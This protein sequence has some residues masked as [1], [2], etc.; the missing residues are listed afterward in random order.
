MNF[1]IIIPVYNVEQYLAKCL[2]SVLN[3]DISYTDYEVILVN[4]GSSDNSETIIQNYAIKHS[5]IRYIKQDNGGP[6]KARNMGL[7]HASGDYIWFVDA[8][9]SIKPNSLLGLLDYLKRHNVDFCEFPYYKIVGKQTYLINHNEKISNQRV[10]NVEYLSKYVLPSM[11]WDYVVKREVIETNN[12]RFTPNIWHEDTEFNLRLL[13]HCHNISF[14]PYP[15]YFYLEDRP[16]STMNNRASEHFIKRIDS[17]CYILNMLKNHYNDYETNGYSFQMN[18]RFNALLAYT[19]LELI[20]L[21]TINS[22]GKI[23]AQII[24]KNKY[25][26]NTKVEV[27]LNKIKYSTL[28]ICIRNYTLSKFINGLYSS[29]GD[30]LYLIIKLIRK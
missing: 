26:Y 14:Y 21:S 13:E 28:N 17:Y 10:S 23:Y 25:R 7:D 29:F 11:P 2:D 5:N 1:S 8:D 20:P 30:A 15:L 16:N 4:D 27:R 18:K 6:S 19:T 24:R 9:D 22:K 3:Q 12:L